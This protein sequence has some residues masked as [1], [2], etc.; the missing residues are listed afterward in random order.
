MSKIIEE[1]YAKAKIM[2][3]LLKKKMS[4][5]SEHPNIA[6][7][8][9]HWITEKQYKDR[10]CVVVEGYSAKRLSELSKFLDGEGAFMLLIEL[11]ENPKNALEKISNGFK[12]K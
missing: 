1:Y 12:I 2:P 6:E 9:E 11:R 5:F 10:N 3:L 4:K 8:F 7:E